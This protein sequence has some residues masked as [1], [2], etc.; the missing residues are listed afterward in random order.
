MSVFLKIDFALIFCSKTLI[1]R[2]R[3][4]FRFW[5]YEK[6]F[7]FHTMPRKTNFLATFSY[8]LLVKHPKSVVFTMF[9]Y[10]DREP[11]VTKLE[12]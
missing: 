7:S 2:P 9:L 6:M 10:P 5:V 1:F 3:M 4:C 12:K 11:A 8:F